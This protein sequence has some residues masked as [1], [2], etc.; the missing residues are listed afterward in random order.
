MKR[1]VI[2]EMDEDLTRDLLKEFHSAGEIEI[3]KWYTTEENQKY[4]YDLPAAERFVQTWRKGFSYRP[5]LT[6]EEEHRLFVL[7][8]YLMANFA[9]DTEFY[10][11]PYYE[12]QE[13]Y[14]CR[15]IFSY[16]L[17]VPILFISVPLWKITASL[18]YSRPETG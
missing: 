11:L 18:K 1:F 15:H 10:R 16:A 8:D 14:I 6:E 7:L 4:F 12:W 3:V 5:V 13:S 2:A 9:R 17:N